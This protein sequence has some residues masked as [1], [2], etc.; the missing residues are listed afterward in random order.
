MLKLNLEHA[1]GHLGFH[2]V[3]NKIKL[4]VKE[5]RRSRFLPTNDRIYIHIISSI[6]WIQSRNIEN[7]QFVHANQLQF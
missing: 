1:K 6:A 7:Y 2:A 5:L 4:T 3:D